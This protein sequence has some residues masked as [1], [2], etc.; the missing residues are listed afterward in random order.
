[1][2]GSLMGPARNPVCADKKE[3]RE[4]LQKDSGSLERFAEVSDSES[5]PQWLYS[6]IINFLTGLDVSEEE[7]RD[8]YFKI[9]DHKFS[10]SDKLERDIGFRV[11]ALDYL[12]NCNRILRNPKFV[13]IEF[14]EKILA[15][16]KEDTKLCCYNM[17]YFEGAVKNE[18]KRADRYN[19]S[20]S[21]I[22]LDLDDF[23]GIN[24]RYGHLFGD[25][26]LER[27]VDAVKANLRSE[28]VL[29]RYGGD[30]FIILLPQ[31]G[32]V[33]ARTM[34]ERIRHRL[35]EY[36]NDREFVLT[37]AEVKF[38]AGIS[39]FPFDAEDYESLVDCADKALYK[40]KFLGKNMIYDYLESERAAGAVAGDKRQ[41]A[42][43]A[44]QNT[45]AVDLM[46]DS[47]LVGV[48][49]RIVNI[50]AHGAFIE[51]SCNLSG[52]LMARPM[53]IILKKLGERGFGGLHIRGNI[54]RVNNE[55]QTLKFYLAL[56]FD[57][58]LNAAQ[59]RSIESS[60]NL[61]PI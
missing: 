46:S 3:F 25:R 60:A 49:G 31:T 5:C 29:A 28:D 54:V 18:I 50:S 4:L 13:E 42:R 22:L 16:S 1:M 57:S 48:D 11:A 36:F 47:S 58:V 37:K 45:S 35:I 21:L 41:T 14:F 15:L 55:T 7:S 20:L 2:G 56:K 23:K 17:N 8:H 12:F 19:Q 9:L 44:V 34:A 52:N 24:D 39:T 33:G 38:S 30:E 51:C 10:L 53:K 61:A 32:R 40:S 6:M 27:F 26:V 59:W 43:F